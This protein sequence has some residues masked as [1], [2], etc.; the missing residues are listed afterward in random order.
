MAIKKE[1]EESDWAKLR[2]AQSLV[3]RDLP[4][5]GIAVITDVG[6]E[7]DIHPTKKGPVGERLALAARKIAYK[8]NVVAFGPTFRSVAIAGDKASVTFDN[9]GKGLEVRGDR[10]TGFAIAGADKVF[11]F[12]DATVDGNRVVVSS[13]KVPSPRYVRF[14]WANYPVVDLWNKD[15]LPANPFRSDPP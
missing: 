7:N 6:E 4:N 13:P 1:P 14:G 3:A 9:V 8:E 2:E 10:L 11:V 12:A 5:V 15:G